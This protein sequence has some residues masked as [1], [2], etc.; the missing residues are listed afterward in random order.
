MSV[1]LAGDAQSRGERDARQQRGR[2]LELSKWFDG[3]A[4]LPIS[5]AAVRTLKGHEE[6]ESG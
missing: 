6:V 4:F 2:A 3:G 1:S 5:N